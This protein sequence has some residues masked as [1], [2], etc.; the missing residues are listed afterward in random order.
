MKNVENT[1]KISII[2]KSNMS[3]NALTFTKL[4]NV[5]YVESFYI[6]LYPKQARNVESK[7][8]SS[9]MPLSKGFTAPI[10]TKTY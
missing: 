2:F 5:N 1:S 8:K 3:F 4:T 7:G 10:F 9:F 6:W